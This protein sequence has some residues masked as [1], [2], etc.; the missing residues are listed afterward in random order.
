MGYEPELETSDKRHFSERG[1]AQFYNLVAG[2]CQVKKTCVRAFPTGLERNLYPDLSFF[3]FI[4]VLFSGNN[5]N[6]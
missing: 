4:A 2:Q 6:I 3:P 1:Q 5:Q